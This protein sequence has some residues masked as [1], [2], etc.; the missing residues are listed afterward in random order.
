MK[1][2]SKI[3]AYLLSLGLAGAFLGVAA[4]GVGYL[5]LAPKLPSV[6]ALRDVE[7]Q[8]PLKVYAADGGLLAEYGEKKRTPLTY[9]EVPQA[10]VDAF[11]AAEDQRFYEHPGVDYQGLIRAIWYLVRTGEKGPGG[12]TITMQVARNFFLTREQTYLRKANEILLA[13][14]IERE[15]TKREILELYVNKIYLGHRAYG[16]GAAAKVYYGKPVREL[17]L[18]QVAMIAGLPKAPSSL[19]PLTNPERARQRRGYVLGRMLEQG[20][21]EEQA[22]A[23][24]MKTPVTTAA[25]GEQASSVAPYLAEMVRQDMVERFGENAAY[26]NGYRVHTTLDVNRQKAARQALRDALHAYDERHGYRGSVDSLELKE[27]PELATLRERLAAYES[28]AELRNALV[29]EVGQKMARV[30]VAGEETP[31]ELG[32]P[33]VEWAKPFQ[34]RERVGAAPEKI[35]DVLGVGDVIRLRVSGDGNYRLA[36]VPEIAGAL[37]SLA[38]AD[39]AIMALVGGYDFY[40]SSFN[41]VTQARRQPGS[42]FKPFIYSAALDKGYTPATLVNDAPVVFRDEALESTWRPENY[43]GQFF[44]PTRLRKAL[45]R[46]RN[47]VSIRVLRDIG[48]PHTVDHAARFGFDPEQLPRNLSL[49]LGSASVTPLELARGYAAFA[50]GGFRVRPYFVTRI[51]DGAGEV[52]YEA[53]PARAC[54]PCEPTDQAGATD[55]AANGDE[56]GDDGGDGGSAGESGGENA[57]RAITAQNNYLMNTMLRDVVQRGTGQGAKALGRGDLA[58]KTG[59]TNDQRDAWF[60]GFNHA[61]V[62]TAWV[63]FDQ[64]QPLGRGETGARAALP[65]WID[66]MRVALEGVPERSLEQP[67]GLVTVRVDAESGLLTSADN[68]NAIFETFREGNLPDPGPSL[69][70][71]GSAEEGVESG[72]QGLF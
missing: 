10:M 26:T 72:G 39:G 66:Y 36:Q 68:P 24:A 28:V 59:T 47:L 42:A 61:V 4:V 40:Q 6:D 63:G 13:L 54:E 1:S 71:G 3:M 48:I 37:V 41:R 15:L 21:I 53:A 9:E 20:F 58:G 52:V 25:A 44:G 70:T 8:V 2:F 51:E 49:A 69:S 43:S 57:P 67:A 62:A 7:L 34:T 29:L 35:A 46:S 64:V 60:S 65:M 55:E 18:A 50:N 11:I 17:D 16:V 14:K 38:P 27:A 32:M 23:K 56:G 33:A 19:N 45:Y 5:V 31:V 22:Y 12:S 30:L